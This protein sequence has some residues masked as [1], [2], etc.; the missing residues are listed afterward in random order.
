MAV[1]HVLCRKSLDG[2]GAPPRVLIYGVDH[3]VEAVPPR[4]HAQY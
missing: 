4:R 1:G 3:F 2:G